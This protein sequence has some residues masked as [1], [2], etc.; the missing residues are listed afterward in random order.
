MRNEEDEAHDV[1]RFGPPVVAGFGIQKADASVLAGRKLVKGKRTIPTID[2]TLD[3]EGKLGLVFVKESEPPAVKKVRS[4]TLNTFDPP[5]LS[6]R[7][8][9]QNWLPWGAAAFVTQ[10][11]SSAGGGGQPR[12]RRDPEDRSWCVE[13]GPRSLLFDSNR[14]AD[15]TELPRPSAAGSGV[16]DQEGWLRG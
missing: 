13:V 2:V 6:T 1:G 9:P 11:W 4:P 15:Q 14:H 8:N 3:G 12:L 16:E 7:S 10:M 5:L